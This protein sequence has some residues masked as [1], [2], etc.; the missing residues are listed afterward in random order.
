M[1]PEE[2]CNAELTAAGFQDLHSAV[3]NN[4][5]RNNACSKFGLWLCC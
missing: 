2:W 3:E 4:K 5:R 1:Y